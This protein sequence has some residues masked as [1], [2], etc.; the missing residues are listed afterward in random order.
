MED[1]FEKN[2]CPKCGGDSRTYLDD[3]IDGEQ[4]FYTCHCEE[5]GNDYVEVWSLMF[6]HCFNVE[7]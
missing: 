3:E 5:C 4:V 7:D 2:R 6:S 1:Y